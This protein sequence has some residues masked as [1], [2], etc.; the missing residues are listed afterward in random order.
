MAKRIGN[1]MKEMPVSGIGALCCAA[2]IVIGISLLPSGEETLCEQL[3]LNCGMSLPLKISYEPGASS[4]SPPDFPDPTVSLISVLPSGKESEL[5]IRLDRREKKDLVQQF[6]SSDKGNTWRSV[7]MHMGYSNL[8]KWDSPGRIMSRVDNRVFYDCYFKCKNGFEV[9]KD[10][11]E[12]WIHINPVLGS[13]NINE[14][15]LVETGIHISSR[16]YARVWNGNV[17]DG[18]I[19]VSE[20]YGQSFRLLQGHVSAI[21]ESRADAKLLF[22][23]Y[24]SDP[25]L[26]ISYNGGKNWI[27]MDGSDE[28]FKPIYRNPILGY[29]RSWKED[30]ND[31]EM[32]PADLVYQ[33]ESDSMH[34]NYIYVNT[35]KGLYISRD[36]GRSFRLSSLAR[37][38]LN[39]VDRIATDPAASGFLY[40]AIDLGQIYRSSDYGCTWKKL[41]IGD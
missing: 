35:Y 1:S 18:R 22:G 15:Q 17:K 37:G 28:F 6:S 19:A 40:A 8:P 14:I 12:R 11:G 20:D 33:V 26:S 9:S 25:W 27:R 39:S 13:S 7:N 24:G 30:K 36:Y 38:R 32:L 41:G 2:I 4:S 10:G 21:V 16:I 29:F 31:I 3:Q 5:L 34:P 23:R